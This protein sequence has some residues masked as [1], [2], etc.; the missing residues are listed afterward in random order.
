MNEPFKNGISNDL[1]VKYK[2]WREIPLETVS[3]GK[4]GKIVE[5]II[6]FAS[7][8]LWKIREIRTNVTN[9]DKMFK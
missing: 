5:N 4:I 1:M 8:D 6:T 7:L 3:S 2:F 9:L